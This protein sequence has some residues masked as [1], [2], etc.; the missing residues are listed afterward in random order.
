MPSK[1]YYNALRRLARRDETKYYDLE[2]LKKLSEYDLSQIGRGLTPKQKAKSLKLFDDESDVRKYNDNP[3]DL[4]QLTVDNEMLRLSQLYEI[5]YSMNFRKQKALQDGVQFAVDMWKS[6]EAKYGIQVTADVMQ[7]VMQTEDY[8][9]LVNGYHNMP[10]SYQAKIED[11]IR[12]E[13][14]KDEADV[15]SKSMAEIDEDYMIEEYD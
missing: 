8:E 4:A 14:G 1:E 3:I 10:L 6:F 7:Q 13:L 2:Q 9:K 12:D 5:S 11:L 15:Y